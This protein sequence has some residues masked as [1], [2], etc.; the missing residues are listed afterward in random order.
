MAKDVL[1]SG[2]LNQFRNPTNPGN[3]RIRPLFKINLETSGKLRG[4]LFD[5]IQPL[6]ILLNQ[7]FCIRARPTNAPMVTMALKN[8][9]KASLV[10]RHDRVTALHKISGNIRL[11][12]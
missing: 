12:I 6:P 5:A 11:N 2:D 3:H 1:T 8:L 7:R 10:K 4:L 9:F